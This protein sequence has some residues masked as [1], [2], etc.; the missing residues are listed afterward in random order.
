MDGSSCGDAL[1]GMPSNHA[2]NFFAAATFVAVTVPWRGWHIVTVSSAVLVAI[3]RVYLAKHYPSQVV[4][5]AGIGMTLGLLGAC[6]Y[7]LPSCLD[8]FWHA[9]RVLYQPS[10]SDAP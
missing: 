10:P 8:R 7:R 6:A 9:P 1:T 4:F 5:G 3:S 2:L